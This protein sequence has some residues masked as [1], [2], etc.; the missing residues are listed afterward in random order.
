SGRSPFC[1]TSTRRPS[2]SRHSPV[3]SARKR[4][5]SKPSIPR[6]DS[7]RGLACYARGVAYVIRTPENVTFEF[8][9]AGVAS[10]A[11]AW[12]IDVLVMGALILGATQLLTPLAAAIG[13]MANALVYIVAF[14]VQWWYATILEWWW[15]GQTIGKRIIGLR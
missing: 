1:S 12:G 15:G 8:E 6:E 4:L 10:R 2:S 9:L 7:S 3:R 5:T 14:V 13:E 11:L